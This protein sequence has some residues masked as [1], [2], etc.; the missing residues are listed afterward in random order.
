ML[1]RY[2]HEAMKRARYKV[3]ENGECFGWVPAIAGVWASEAT[4]DECQEVLQ[5]VLEEWLVLKIRDHDPI[6]RIGRVG[7]S[8]KAA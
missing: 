5:E 4:R 8:L 6:P 3:I 7:L 1:S 2:I